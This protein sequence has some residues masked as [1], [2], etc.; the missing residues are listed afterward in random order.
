M[1]TV[2]ENLIIRR[3]AVAVELAALDATKPGGMPDIGGRDGGTDIEHQA[4]KLNLYKELEYLDGAIK[5]AQ[6]VA[7]NGDPFEIETFVEPL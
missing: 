6:D 5:R 7:D 2:L 1:A 3:E 4:Y